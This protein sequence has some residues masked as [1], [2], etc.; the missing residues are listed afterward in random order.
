MTFSLRY[1]L[2]LSAWSLVT[3]VLECICN[4]TAV[5]V[6]AA[7]HVALL[8]NL[9]VLVLAGLLGKAKL[10]FKLVDTLLGNLV[11]H[12]AG[13]VCYSLVAGVPVKARVLFTYVVVDLLL[14][15]RV[16]S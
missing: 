9:L 13:L 6:G 2:F 1:S 15:S 11:S 4:V 10:A 8:F 5:Q 14:S 7:Y 16:S 12:V 3:H